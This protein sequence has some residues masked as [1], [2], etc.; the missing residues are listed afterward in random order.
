MANIQDGVLE[1]FLSELEKTEEFSKERVG[2]LRK[3]FR[4]GKKP[5]AAD[6]VKILSDEPEDQHS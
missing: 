6:L 1:T 2:E 4:R 5:K 3:A